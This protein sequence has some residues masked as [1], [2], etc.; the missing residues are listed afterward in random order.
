MKNI[1]IVITISVIFVSKAFTAPAQNP[2]LLEAQKLESQGD[3]EQAKKIFESLYISDDEDI[4]FY[5]LISLYVYTRDF[6]SLE[7]LALSKLKNNPDHLEAKR[8]LARAFYEQGEKEKARKFLL[9]II[10]DN[11]KD[12]SKIKM[13][14][15]EFI[16]Q[17]EYNDAINVYITAREINK[18]P[19]LFSIEMARIYTFHE[20]YISAIEEYLKAL[21][22]SNVAYTNIEQLI[23]K[24]IKAEIKID[25]LSNLFTDFVQKNPG[26][27]KAAKL[28][29]ELL[30]REGDYD[31]SYRV[32]IDPAVETESASDIWNLAERFRNDRHL[33]KALE[34]Y[35]DYYR[36]FKNAPNRIDALKQSASIK[37]ELGRKESAIDDYQILIDDY[38]GTIHSAYAALRLIEL[39]QDKASFEGYTGILDEFAS[40]TEFRE[41]AFEA[42]LLLGETFLRK[43][44]LDDT[45]QAFSSARLKARGN[46]EMYNISLKSAYLHFFEADYEAM[47]KEIEICIRN[48]P[49]GEDIND[50]LTFKIL[51]MKCSSDRDIKGFNTFSRGHYA[52]YRGDIDEAIENFKEAAKDTFSVVAPYAASA[53][54]KIYR[55]QENFTEAVKWYLYAADTAQDTTVHVGAIIEAAN[56]AGS[57][58]NNKESAKA[59]Y[60]ESI[61]SYPGNI[62]ESELR[63]KLRM[64]VEE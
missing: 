10:G 30:Y 12:I 20:N 21:E 19:L 15:D 31:G 64:L 43:G 52:L 14:A 36:Y 25:E 33:E 27:I 47:S 54:G 8:Y 41:V 2:Q 56:I 58:L 39:S 3:F 46:D 11:W 61:I 51:G 35:K 29:S 23:N 16:N 55:S 62:Y 50:L 13:V 24:A 22:K 7:N 6:K 37:H 34:V 53:L 45:K 38:S 59:L 60:L 1:F 4:Y 57:E 17:N 26:S 48:L 44:I 5:K 42:Y 28:L 63:N 32:L 18:N 40:T 49:D 9:E